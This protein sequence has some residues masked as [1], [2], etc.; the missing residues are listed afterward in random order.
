MCHSLVIGKLPGLTLQGKN[1]PDLAAGSA[2]S[3][4]LRRERA[5]VPARMSELQITALGHP[6]LDV[7]SCQ[8]LEGAFLQ[9]LFF[10]NCSFFVIAI[11][12]DL[13]KAGAEEERGVHTETTAP[14]KAGSGLFMGE[15]CSMQGPQGLLHVAVAAWLCRAGL[16]RVCRTLSNSW[17][18]SAQ[19]WPKGT[20]QL[21]K[22][23][24]RLSA[25]PAAAPALLQSRHPQ[26]SSFACQGALCFHAELGW[27][28]RGG[29]GL[30]G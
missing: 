26:P 22:H 14:H 17:G 30:L 11:L 9:L 16:G 6:G 27:R 23:S 13:L 15:L 5:C 29:L 2:V 28:W 19:P 24:T 25:A 21:S 7:H 18:V 3:G 12:P 10:C 20:L 4:S 1:N 8:A